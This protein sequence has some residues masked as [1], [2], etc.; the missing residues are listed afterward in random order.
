[1][2]SVRPEP[3][4]GQLSATG[5]VRQAHHKRQQ[6]VAWSH[7]IAFNPVTPAQAGAYTNVAVSRL[8][9]PS[10]KLAGHRQIGLGPSLRWG[11]GNVS[12]DP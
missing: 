1:M 11:D 2:S 3:V 8:F 5:V 4:E 12:C 9:S 7:P 6:T 10:A